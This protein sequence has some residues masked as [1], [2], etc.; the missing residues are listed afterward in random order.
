[1][2][3]SSVAIL[4]LNWNGK[5]DTIQCLQSVAQSTYRDFRVY[6][7]D[8]GS[9]ETELPEIETHW[10][11]V[12]QGAVGRFYASATNL[13]FAG[14]MNFLARQAMEDTDFRA[15]AFLLLNNDTLPRPDFLE[16]LVAA[17]AKNPNV[18]VFGSIVLTPEPA[19]TVPPST[20]RPTEK[21]H[22]PISTGWLNLW[23]GAT[24]FT[25]EVTDQDLAPCDFVHGCSFFVRA[26]LWKKLNGL[27]DEY[28]AYYEES[29]FCRRAKISGSA[30]AVVRASTILHEGSVSVNRMSGLQEFFMMRNRILF[31][32]KN[33]NPIQK[34][35]AY[36]Y[37]VFVYAFK[38]A[39]R[40]VL[41]T[42]FP[43]LKGVWLGLIYGF[44]GIQ[45][46]GPGVARL[47]SKKPLGKQATA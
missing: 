17:A 43:A 14:G 16:P 24:P 25:H 19:S 8:N 30:V 34:L 11:K 38:R 4:I 20:R 18:G 9:R 42:Q 41:Y 10:K 47:F 23:T 33:S 36:P 31:I 44:G 29:D 37:S 35:V 5:S 13:G 27:D 39:A 12:S 46:D 40:A 22:P 15:D 26:D 32:R 1:M 6:V 21:A 2:K 28:F 7:L 45:V 3:A